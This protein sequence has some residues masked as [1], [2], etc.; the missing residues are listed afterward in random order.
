MADIAKHDLYITQ[1]KNELAMKRKYLVT[2]REQLRKSALQNQYLLPILREYDMLIHKHED[3]VKRQKLAL[4]D[5]L[6][7]LQKEN[8]GMVVGGSADADN[9]DE[10]HIRMIKHKIAE[11]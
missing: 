4:N 3:C 10:D 9:V 1:L 8:V 7:W 11:L 2:K 5:L 6:E